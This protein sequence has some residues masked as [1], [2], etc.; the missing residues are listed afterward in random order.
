M[1]IYMKPLLYPGTAF[2]RR[3]VDKSCPPTKDPRGGATATGTR[4]GGEGD[5]IGGERTEHHDT[6]TNYEQTYTQE[7]QRKIQEEPVKIT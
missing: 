5:R 3:G 7:T 1:P 6:A 2:T 4:T